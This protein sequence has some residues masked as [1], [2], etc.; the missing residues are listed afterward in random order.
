M[1]I[2]DEINNRVSEHRL[3]RLI[4]VNQ[5]DPRRRTVLMSEE[6]TGMVMGPWVEGPMGERCGRLRADLENFVTGE[7]VTVCLT[8]REAKDAQIARL[9]PVEDEVWDFRCQEPSPGLRVFC[10]FAE[11]DILVAMTCYPRSLSLPWWHR[12]P[13][14]DDERRWRTAI[15]E[16]RSDWRKLFPA[17]EPVTGGCLDDYLSNAVLQ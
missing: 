7:R 8:P 9:E 6:I 12:L 13:L 10:R 3:T 15:V 14:L 1:S 17:H 2:R 4:P 5:K 16:C 11:K